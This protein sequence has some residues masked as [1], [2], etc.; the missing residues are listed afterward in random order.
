MRY[1]CDTSPLQSTGIGCFLVLHRCCIFLQIECQTLHQQKDC[2][3]F[4][5]DTRFIVLVWTWTRSVSKIQCDGDV[6]TRAICLW[7][8]SRGTCKPCGAEN[9]Q[10]GVF[11]LENF[12]CR[13]STISKEIYHRKRLLCRGPFPRQLPTSRINLG[14]LINTQ[15]I[16]FAARSVEI[17]PSDASS[18]ASTQ[19][20]A[21]FYKLVVL[22]VP[23]CTYVF[24]VVM[25]VEPFWRQPGPVWFKRHLIF[26]SYPQ[27]FCD[28]FFKFF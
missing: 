22:W 2:D 18:L 4:D 7:L 16:H 27:L 21:V 17:Q 26:I 19:H 5:C 11:V 12:T 6:E 25:C 15:P 1:T 28:P 23:P 8:P 14:T 13:K 3:S 9:T 24:F 10:G 20:W